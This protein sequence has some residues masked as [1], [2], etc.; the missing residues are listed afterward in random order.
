MLLLYETSAVYKFVYL[1]LALQ[2]AGWKLN[3]FDNALLLP[4]WNDKIENLKLL[5]L[6]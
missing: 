1:T 5:V 2:G 4:H 3:L 6:I